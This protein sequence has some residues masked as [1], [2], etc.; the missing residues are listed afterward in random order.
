MGLELYEDYT[1]ADVHQLFAPEQNF[2][3]GGGTWG[4]QGIV[5][6]PNRSADFI[7]Y[8]SFGRTIADHDF[9]E[10]ISPSGVL[11][12]QSQPAQ[13][14]D[15]DRIRQFIGHDE[16][17]SNIYLFLRTTTDSKRPY[18]YMGRLKYLRHDVQREMPVHFQWQI[19][20]WD[21]PAGMLE[22]MG[23]VL[24]GPGSQGPADTPEIATGNL[25]SP[26]QRSD[27]SGQPLNT[28]NFRARKSPDWSKRDA[29]NRSL[30]AAGERFVV[31]WERSQL[32]D[33]GFPDLAAQVRHIA[34][35]IGDG[36]GYDVHSYTTSGD[37]KYI[38]VKTT[39]GAADTDF[40]LTENERR[41]ALERNAE[42]FLYRVYDFDQKNGKGNLFVLSGPLEDSFHLNATQYRVRR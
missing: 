34:A 17:A 29:A 38:E 26:P 37:P 15:H 30:G 3:P 8:V 36:A 25:C 21:P 12:W 27:G 22:R 1:R 28:P 5:P 40:F 31:E 35:E 32:I 41:F 18:T 16:Q 33:S 6:L 14:L 24:E 42:F 11:T 23:L 4:L 19:L 13:A 7:F 39:K 10:G 2:H 9:D 20:D